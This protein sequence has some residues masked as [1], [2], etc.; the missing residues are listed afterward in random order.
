MKDLLLKIKEKLKYIW[1]KSKEDDDR[2]F[3]WSTLRILVYFTLFITFIYRGS[4]VPSGSM[5]PGLVEGDIVLVSKFD[6]G[7]SRY[8]LPFNIPLIS[9]RIFNF[10]KPK[11]GDVVVFALPKDPGT[12]FVKR[13]IGLPGETIQLK[14]SILYING[15][16]IKR[17]YIGEYYDEFEKEFLLKFKEDLTPKKT[18]EVL[19][20]KNNQIDIRLHYV[21]NTPE[22]K[23]PE[24]HYLFMGDNRDNSLDSRFEE[25]G[26]I[27]EKYLFGRVNIILFSRVNSLWKIW[28]FPKNFSSKNIRFNR[29]LK[30]VR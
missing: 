29:I 24:K 3:S 2:L 6:Y 7:F 15:K 1:Q 27:H 22:I 16:E 21:N 10:F 12:L 8:S 28:E 13:V 5:K 11:R 4:F 14:N 9:G 23:I 20:S 18:I 19:Q 25:T 26:L 17:E 30:I